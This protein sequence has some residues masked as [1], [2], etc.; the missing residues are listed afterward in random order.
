VL[1]QLGANAAAV[2]CLA[3]TRS[4]GAA[5]AHAWQ[6]AVAGAPGAQTAVIGTSVPAGA[7]GPLRAYAF[8]QPAAPGS[9]AAAAL[10]LLLINLAPAPAC[11]DMPAF[12][13]AGA[14]ATQFTLTPGAPPP[15]GTSVESPDTLL[16]GALLQA[17]A[18]GGLPDAITKM[19]GLSVPVTS[20]INLPPTSISFVLVPLSRA[21]GAM[22]ACTAPP[23]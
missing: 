2:W 1:T 22:P 23:S 16:N 18:S 8:C 17:D 20:S 15:G 5:H 14:N 4:Y 6:R 19:E 11:V 13:T 9:G 3:P 12:A 10:T 7:G 21:A